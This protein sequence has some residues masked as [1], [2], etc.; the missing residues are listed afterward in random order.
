MPATAVTRPPR[1]GPM[2]R[3]RSAPERS[4][5]CCAAAGCSAAIA[6]VKA[7]N[8]VAFIDIDL[9]LI[10]LCAVCSCFRRPHPPPGNI[11][12]NAAVHQ[13]RVA[14]E[15][16]LRRQR[17]AYRGGAPWPL[18]AGQIG[19]KDTGQWSASGSRIGSIRPGSRT[20]KRVGT[21]EEVPFA[22]RRRAFG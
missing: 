3:Q 22:K 10:L 20:G 21:D 6:I 13:C 7:T 12:C 1:N 2:L 18:L 17:V 16:A 5:G 14:H 19:L 15:G 8:R 4:G 9:G 11:T